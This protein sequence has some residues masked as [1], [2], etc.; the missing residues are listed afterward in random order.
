MPVAKSHEAA[1]S[2]VNL[3]QQVNSSDDHLLRGAVC[4]THETI[5]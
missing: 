2:S 5:K 4:T 3:L 1:D